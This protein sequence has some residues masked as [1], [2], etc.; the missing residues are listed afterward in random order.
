M[1]CGVVGLFCLIML[2]SQQGMGQ[3][4]ISTTWENAATAY[5]EADYIAAAQLYQSLLPQHKDAALLHYNLAN[6]YYRLDQVAQAILHYQRA[7]KLQPGNEE[8]RANL[9]L[10]HNRVEEAVLPLPE[11][12]LQRWVRQGSWLCTPVGWGIIS[13]LFL[14][15]SVG[16]AIYNLLRGGNRIRNRVSYTLAGMCVL[17]ILLGAVRFTDLRSDDHGVIM[18]TSLTLLAAPD[19]ESAAVRQISAGETVEILDILD[20]FYKVRLVNYE[21]G[22]VPQRAVERI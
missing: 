22:W 12:F 5:A 17:S 16:L 15:G 8:A 4:D 1:K 6:C 11:F 2:G 19:S 3:P 9:K 10:A 7:L 14:W 20:V 13:L 21:E 18:D